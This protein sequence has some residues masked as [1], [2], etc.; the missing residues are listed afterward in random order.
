MRQVVDAFD[1]QALDR[2]GQRGHHQWRNQQ[3]EPE[4]AGDGHGGV[5]QVG[6]Q[7]EKRAVGEVD[8]VEQAENDRQAHGDEEVDHPQAQA[9]EQLEQV[10]IEHERALDSAPGGCLYKCL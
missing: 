10:Q 6:A 1:Q 5:A 3:R 9:V 4:V 8:E 2:P 7:Q